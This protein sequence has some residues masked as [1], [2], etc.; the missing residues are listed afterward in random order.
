MPENNLFCL[1][2]LGMIDLLIYQ[3][4]ILMG[5][6]R[7]HQHKCADLNTFSCQYVICKGSIFLDLL[8]YIYTIYTMS[9]VLQLALYA[10]N[11]LKFGQLLSFAQDDTSNALSPNISV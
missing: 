6:K 7:L 2:H 1:Q 5:W 10:Q 11:V 3:D 4:A 9:C 8:Q